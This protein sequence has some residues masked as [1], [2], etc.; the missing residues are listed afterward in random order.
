MSQQQN[1]Y[2]SK[3]PVIDLRKK[4]Q[5]TPSK[6]KMIFEELQRLSSSSSLKYSTTLGKSFDTERWSSPRSANR[7]NATLPPRRS[8]FTPSRL[9][10]FSAQL[11]REANK[12]YWRCPKPS[13]KATPRAA[14]IKSVNPATPQLKNS[15]IRNI[16]PGIK[17]N[18]FSIADDDLQVDSSFNEVNES[19]LSRAPQ[20]ALSKAPEP[21]FLSPRRPEPPMIFSFSTPVVRAPVY[22]EPVPPPVLVDK[23]TETEPELLPE[24]QSER[25]SPPAT[26]SPFTTSIV[27][28]KSA[29]ATATAAKPS[30][31]F[32][33]G[34][35][36]GD[37]TSA[38]A[39]K[40]GG[41]T[42]AD[43]L[44]S[45]RLGQNAMNGNSQSKFAPAPETS[46]PADATATAAKPSSTFS[47]GFRFGDQTSAT[48]PKNGGTTTVDFLSSGRLGQNAMNGN[49]QSKL[50]PAFET[51]KPADATAT[52]AKPSSTF[53][54]GFLFG[55]QTSATAPKHGR[56][57][58]FDFLS[59]G[60]LG[61]NAMNGNSQSKLAP[62]SET[63]ATG[64]ASAQAPKA[65]G[66][67]TSAFLFANPSTQAPAAGTFSTAPFVFGGLTGG[68]QSTGG[69]QFKPAAPSLSISATSDTSRY[70]LFCFVEL[71]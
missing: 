48:A 22:K 58:T 53:S 40:H 23:C 12:P 38:T 34:F 64:D 2:P 50:A 15:R 44:S 42:T 51:S 17:S 32:S 46:K 4:V 29:D 11:E 3:P 41:T 66:A 33:A 49:S 30:S 62:A 21:G 54:A 47:A 36:F 39:P 56:T 6:T 69:F 55:D 63:S 35:L 65:D 43:F 8:M 25:K 13:E 45:G 60:R 10:E 26:V 1:L 16:D 61:Q 27:Q 67:A 28:S 71:I 24:K 68:L 20:L 19:D 70:A 52:A 37:Q 59:N 57:T 9:Q 7:S 31:T 5:P 14:A 18:V